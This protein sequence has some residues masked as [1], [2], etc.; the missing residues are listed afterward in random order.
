MLEKLADPRY[1]AI[2]RPCAHALDLATRVL[3]A[4]PDP[5]VCEVGVGIG[6]T[7]LEICRKLDHRGEA[8]FFD[9]Q[10]RLNELA[11]DLS[12]AGFTNIRM[13][14]N[15]RRTFDG[16]GW[17][18]AMLLR[19]TLDRGVS[20]L[21]DFVYLDGAHTFHHDAPSTV[22]LKDLLK[23]GGYIL[24]DDYDWT[25]AVSPTM[26][27]SVCPAVEQHY[28]DVQIEL[29]HVEMVCSLFLDSDPRF[30]VVPLG[31]RGREHRRAYRRIA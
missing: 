18:L 15:S 7:S 11:A 12:A 26:R 1:Q 24:M 21:I 27:P 16:Y 29:S 9:Y 25:I 6:A 28:T 8:W 17:N 13:F 5:I 20:G 30:V 23:V 2:A 4:T 3:A 31:Y 14:G 19:Q 10:D 22:C